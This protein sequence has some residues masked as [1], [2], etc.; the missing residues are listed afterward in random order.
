MKLY[1]NP[2]SRAVISKW[3][4]DEAGA[5]YELEPI[6][7]ASGQHRSP[8]FLAI[9]P[10]GKLPAL[11]DGEV[12]VFES[13]AIGLYVAD[14]YPEARLAPAPGAPERGLY[15][16]WMVY[17]TSQLEPAIGDKLMGQQVHRLRGWTDADRALELLEAQ[18]GQGP[19]L[20][21]DQFTA[22]DI[23]IGSQLAWFNRELPPGLAAYVERLAQRPHAAPMRR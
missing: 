7:F 20:L 2:R 12:I 1:F 10:S 18:V 5:S 14:R 16:S 11:V 8:E 13:V 22:A 19:W 23:L 9:S 17:A 4:L 3:L 21:G 6:D 15:L